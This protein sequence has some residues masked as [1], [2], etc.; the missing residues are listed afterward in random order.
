MDINH[1]SIG[2]VIDELGTRLTNLSRDNDA[3]PG[4]FSKGCD[5]QPGK[6]K[7]VE[8]LDRDTITSIYGK[9]MHFKTELLLIDPDVLNS[10]K[11]GK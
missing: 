5:T 7:P 11:E 6:G 1:M 10:K 2:E 3:R 9:L 4:T 8:R